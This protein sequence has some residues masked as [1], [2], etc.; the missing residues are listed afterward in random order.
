[1]WVSHELDWFFATRIRIIFADLEPTARNETDPQ[2]WYKKSIIFLIKVEKVEGKD[3]KP[4][5]LISMDR[6]KLESVGAP[7]IAAFLNK[8][9][10]YKATAD[11]K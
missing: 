3:G 2:H 7:A 4:D 11:I 10:I 9:Q 5:L 1:M 6:S 8:L